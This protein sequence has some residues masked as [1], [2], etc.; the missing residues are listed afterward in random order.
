MYNDGE[1]LIE[2]R[3]TSV[4]VSAN[5]QSP[6]PLIAFFSGRFR[7]RSKFRIFRTVLTVVTC[8][9]KKHPRYR[10]ICGTIAL[11]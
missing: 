10:C 4:R 7:S 11:Q 8:S 2:S 1:R 6:C 9:C 3:E 5:I